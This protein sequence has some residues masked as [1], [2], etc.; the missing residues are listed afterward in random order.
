M[1]PHRSHLRWAGASPEDQRA[2]FLDIIRADPVVCAALEAARALDLPDWWIVSGVLYNSVWNH[3]TARPAGH[4][5]KDVDLFYF[6][7]ADLSWE[8]EDRVIQ[9]AAPV[10]AHLPVQVEIKN[11]ARVH[12][13]YPRTFGRPCPRYENAAQSIDFFASRTH[14]VGARLN[15]DDSVDLVAPFGLDDMFSFRV[16][17]N[18]ALDNR[19]THEAKAMRAKECWPELDVVPWDARS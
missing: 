16:T 7:G 12:L 19:E 3:L 14:A 5:I 4:G 18:H 11:Q 6:D 1:A 10:L 13:W 17:P 9:D 15:R 8:A 2:A